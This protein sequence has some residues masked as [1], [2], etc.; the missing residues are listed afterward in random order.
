LKMPV[1]FFIGRHDHQV[2]AE[3]SAAYF[4]KLIAPAKELVWFEESAHMPPF[5]EADKFN[6]KLVELVAPAAR[7]TS[8]HT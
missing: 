8:S 4:A 7:A 1:F 3:T 2:A 5:E 6:A